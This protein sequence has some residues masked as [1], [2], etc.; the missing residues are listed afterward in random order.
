MAKIKSLL[1]KTLHDLTIRIVG[2]KQFVLCNV[3]NM[4]L[5]AEP[6]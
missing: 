4:I 3:P 5:E 1:L 6:S 2:G